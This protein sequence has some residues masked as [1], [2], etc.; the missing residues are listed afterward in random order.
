MT[1]ELFQVY[2]I[3]EG[4][5]IILHGNTYYVQVIEPSGKDHSVLWLVDD[6]GFQRSVVV[7]DTTLIPVVFEETADV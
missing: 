4:D 5:T 6:E 7:S 2:S 3:E 1:T